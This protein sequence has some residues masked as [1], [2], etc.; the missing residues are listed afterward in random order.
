M[1]C[2]VDLM[3][4]DPDHIS[5]ES[6]CHRL[7]TT[8]L[9]AREACDNLTEPHEVYEAHKACYF[10]Q[11]SIIMIPT[12]RGFASGTSRTCPEPSRATHNL[13]LAKYRTYIAQI[14]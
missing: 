3:S 1:N 14:G 4:L 8:S 9:Q 5:T 11:N 10:K 2:I 13:F 6:H 7:V 12:F